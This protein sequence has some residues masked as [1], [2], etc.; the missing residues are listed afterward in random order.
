MTA[1]RWAQSLKPAEAHRPRDRASPGRQG[2]C[3][4]ATSD[5]RNA[6]SPQ[7]GLL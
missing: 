7:T 2:T 1:T 3:P 4:L 5:R 6:A